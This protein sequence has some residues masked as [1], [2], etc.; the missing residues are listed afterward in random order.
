MGSSVLWARLFKRD[1]SWIVARVGVHEISRSCD[2]HHTVEKVPWENSWDNSL[3]GA[4][5][6]DRHYI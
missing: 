2:R 1:M 6:C 4:V 5:F 3:I